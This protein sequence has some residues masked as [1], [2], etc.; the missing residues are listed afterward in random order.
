[1]LSFEHKKSIFHSFKEL[2]EKLI[3][4]NRINFVYPNSLQKGKTLATQLHPSGNGYVVGKYMDP[5]TIIKKGY[6]VDPRGW[7]K[8]KNF[9]LKELNE[10]ISTAM[11]SMSGTEARG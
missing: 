4:N 7:I 1:M 5:E 6:E 11:I 3:S 10:I 8:I 2:Q 9:S